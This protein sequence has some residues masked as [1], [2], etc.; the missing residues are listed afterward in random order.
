MNYE[1]LKKKLWIT[2]VSSIFVVVLVLTYVPQAVSA[3]KVIKW[4]VSLW[5][6]PRCWTNPL[7]KWAKDMEKLTNGRWQIK[8]HY[9]GVLAPPKEELDGLKA[10]LFEA[11]QFCAAYHPGKVPL[12]SV[13]ELPFI[14]P[15]D[16][17]GISSMMAALWEHP[18]LLKELEKWNAVPLLPG[19]ILPYNLMGN[20]LIAKAEDFK[21]VRIRIGGEIARVLKMFGAVPTLMPA[22]EVYEA[23]SRGTL[24]M[25]GFPWSFTFGTFK[26]YEVSKYANVNLNL[27]T[28][29]CA[30]VAN[31]K[32]WDAL[33][34]DFKKIHMK[35]YAKAPSEWAKEYTKGDRKWIPI[36]KKRLEFVK[37]SP[38]E[39]AKLVKKAK[40]V[41]EEWVK[42]WEKRGLPARE[43]LNYYLS[44]RKE[45]CGY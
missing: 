24:D 10:G 40:I 13:L 39:R 31:K 17:L 35:W 32:A 30:Y 34:D 9:A 45:I 6:G 20:T 5:G 41:W 27:G 16:G 14:A 19:A 22:P 21:G 23:I 28:M 7:E 4:N 8:L 1:H 12:H 2:A 25:V 11:C 3:P 29:S 26:I 15:N 44:K 42:K 18:A 33:P 37:F 36:F 38:E 43:V